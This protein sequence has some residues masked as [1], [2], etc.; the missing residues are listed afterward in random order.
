MTLTF[1]PKTYADL[2]GQCQPKVIINDREND[3]AIAIIEE[4]SH[5]QNRIP[6]EDALLELR[7]TLVEKF[8]DEQYPMPV[9]SP[10]EMLQHLLEARGLIQEDLVGIIGSRDVVSEVM[11]GKRKISNAQASTLGEF[12]SVAPS[13]FVS[14]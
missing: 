3:K 7:V 4:L 5:R 12:F 9:L 6:E 8:E 13:V 2:L 11:N 14:L 10:L 1:D